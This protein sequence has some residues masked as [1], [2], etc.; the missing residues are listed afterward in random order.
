MQ[1]RQTTL[2]DQTTCAGQFASRH[3]PSQHKCAR[4]RAA[5]PPASD[6]SETEERNLP[7]PPPPPADAAPKKKMLVLVNR[8]GLRSALAGQRWIEHF[9][10]T[11]NFQ[12]MSPERERESHKVARRGSTRPRALAAPP[13]SKILG[14]CQVHF[15]SRHTT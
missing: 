3:P 12:R 4:S 2:E 11:I 6:D 14:S 15:H 7:P 9:V 5:D 10:L 8:S 13:S 1:P